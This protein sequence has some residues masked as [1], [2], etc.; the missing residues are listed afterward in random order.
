MSIRR[1]LATGIP[2]SLL[3]L[4]A[5]AAANPILV[6][7]GYD[8]SSVTID[9]NE[10]WV[11][12]CWATATI[13]DSLAG[14]GMMM[15]ISD[16]WEFDSFEISVGGLGHGEAIK[17][18]SLAFVA[19]NIFVASG[20]GV[21]RFFTFLGWFSG[22]TLQWEQPALID[23][24]DGTFISATFEEFTE[25]G[26]GNTTIV[27]ATVGRAVAVPEPGTLALL[28]LGLVAL[29]AVSRSRRRTVQAL[30]IRNV[31]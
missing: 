14:S 11:V 13:L 23:V 12:D 18:A 3:A 27:S 24:G 22:G 17:Q 2:V 31:S 16:V 26:F 28:G 29:A 19:P 20:G 7:P 1:L 10:D 5:T 25:L 4:A 9:V 21:G 30:A 8:G 15:D 6:D